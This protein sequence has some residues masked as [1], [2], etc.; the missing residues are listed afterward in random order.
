[1]NQSFLNLQN[2]VRFI[3]RNFVQEKYTKGI[4]SHET[5]DPKLYS[6]EFVLINLMYDAKL[7]NHCDQVNQYC[8][9]HVLDGYVPISILHPGT[10]PNKACILPFL[11]LKF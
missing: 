11:S 6:E 10:A 9:V 3:Q 8:L 5:T 2:T 7:T 4:Q 1:M